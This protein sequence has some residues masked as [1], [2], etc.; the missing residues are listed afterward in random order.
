MKRVLLLLARGFEVL[1]G[2]AF[3]DVFGWAATYGSEPVEIVSGAFHP[4]VR[5]AFGFEVTPDVMLEKFDSGDFH[6]LAIPGG[7]ETAGYYDDAFSQP[8]L[9]I[10][11]T[12]HREKKPIASIC[13]GALPL[14]KS[15]ILSGRPATTYHLSGGRRMKQLADLGACAVPGPLVESGDVIT[16]SSPA[17]AVEVALR[18]LE[19]LTNRENAGLIRNLMGFS[20]E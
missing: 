15:G 18:L 6:G 16:S 8:F 20:G 19:K 5:C 4:R 9:D 1:E 11:E 17:T 2:A 12:L 14:A 13:V 3:A 7:F 10:I